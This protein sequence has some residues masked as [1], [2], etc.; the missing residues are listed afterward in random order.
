MAV[1]FQVR[2]LNRPC[3]VHHRGDERF[4]DHDHDC[5]RAGRSADEKGRLG[6]FANRLSNLVLNGTRVVVTK[7]AFDFFYRILLAVLGHLF[8][9]SRC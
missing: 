5:L 2:L 4:R 1:R 6:R 9:E 8:F 3:L 7:A